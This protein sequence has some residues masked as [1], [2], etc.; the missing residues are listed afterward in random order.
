MDECPPEYQPIGQACFP[1]PPSALDGYLL[2]SPF[3]EE[4]G[5]AH[6]KPIILFTII[7]AASLSVVF[8]SLSYFVPRIFQRVVIIITLLILIYASLVCFGLLE[9]PYPFS[10]ALG[11]VNMRIRQAC[12]VGGT[13]AA[14]ILLGW[15]VCF[16]GE[17]SWNGL[18]MDYAAKI[19]PQK[20]SFVC[21]IFQYYAGMT[22]AFAIFA[23]QYHSFSH[24]SSL[25]LSWTVPPSSL[26]ALQIL[27][28]LE[29]FWN[30][31][32]MK[33]SRKHM[34]TQSTYH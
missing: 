34:S 12:A 14:I 10:E 15:M 33:D 29:Y 9:C 18:M 7:L 16:N 17:I 5:Q 19:L 11:G 22:I 20:I 26:N 3:G 8:L 4:W 13:L 31:Q 23:F 6:F 21:F 24:S 27:N 25:F 32:F 1:L 30:L 2:Q 28:I